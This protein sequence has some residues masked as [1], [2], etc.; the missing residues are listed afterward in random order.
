MLVRLIRG[1]CSAK[2]G[3]GAGSAVRGE[4]ARVVG[5]TRGSGGT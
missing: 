5:R 1:S 3:Y 2:G 4:E